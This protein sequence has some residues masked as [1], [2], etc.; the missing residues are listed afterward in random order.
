MV[1]SGNFF[2]GISIMSTF[3]GQ[4]L[5]H[6][7]R[8]S[9]AVLLTIGRQLKGRNMS[10]KSICF[11]L[12]SLLSPKIRDIE[13]NYDKIF[14]FIQRVLLASALTCSNITSAYFSYIHK[15]DRSCFPDGSVMSW[16]RELLVL[17]IS[18]VT[19]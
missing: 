10:N 18:S 12:F 16:S 13:Y 14:F 1:V 2:R 7:I 3:P 6:G 15:S 19:M 4:C 9:V 17:F 5:R 8:E 11:N